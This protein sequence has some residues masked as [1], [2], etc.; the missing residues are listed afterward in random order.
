MKRILY[1]LFLAFFLSFA[2]GME[3]G[4]QQLDQ[5]Q[6]DALASRLSE[7][8]E[9]LKYESLDVQKAECDFL[10]SSCRDSLTRQYVALS[11][12]DHYI[13]SG[14]MGAEAVAI[15]VI[16][17]WFI[18]GKVRMRDDMEL[19]GA[20]VFA[21]FNRMSQLGSKAPGLTMD[22]IDGEVYSFFGPEDKGG[23]FRVLYFYDTDCAKCKIQTVMMRNLL[24]TE[25]F[26]ID[27]IAV[28]ASGNE[29]EWRRYVDSQLTFDAGN[30]KVHN[31]WDPDLDSDFQR[32]YGVIQTPRTFLIGPDGTILGRGLDAQALSRM[33]HG[34]FDEVELE[35]GTEESAALY[36]GI[37][38]G[39]V[40]TRKDIADVADHIAA[41]TLEEGDTVMFRQMTGDLLYWLASERG[42]GVKEGTE[43]LIDNYILS[44]G[45]VWKTADDSLKIIGFA[46]MTDELLSLAAPGSRIADIKVSGTRLSAGK[47]KEGTFRL[48]KLKGDPGI[49][50]F[51]TEGC[52]VC[53]AEKAA[54]REYVAADPK[55]K[56][57][58]VNVDRI[59]SSSP[60]VADRLFRSFD[61]STLP[62][63]VMTD[64]KGLIV[65]RYIS[66]V[67]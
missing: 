34:I 16:D 40:L 41:S 31:L 46:E 35:Y 21:E 50:I 66:L 11:I 24:E 38:Q 47:V 52:H 7:Y 8:F 13:D 23:R 6:R 60:A 10:I 54:A 51:Y 53:D 1:I 22:S 29:D 15:H 62:F 64:R 12:Y 17:N 65:R 14:I 9:A 57:L 32:K 27:L 5:S 48:P 63:I 67:D 59:V 26:P 36:D 58:M 55:V 39:D 18:P 49:I 4:A 33:L 28:Y 30:M 19:L 45:D 44:R 3:S 20:K 56:V 43:Y 25:D 37:F 42:E 2:G 61:L